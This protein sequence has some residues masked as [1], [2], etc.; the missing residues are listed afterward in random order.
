LFPLLLLL[1]SSRNKQVQGFPV[2]G[3]GQATIDGVRQVLDRLDG[4]NQWIL[5]TSMREEPVIYVNG[6]PYVVRDADAPF[7]NI[8]YTGID[9][10]HIELIEQRLKVDIERE[11]KGFGGK[12]LLHGMLLAVIVIVIAMTQPAAS[13]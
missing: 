9:T 2:H 8:D 6:R 5:W 4:K 1:L 11:A 3:V 7:R 10:I 13:L 12:I